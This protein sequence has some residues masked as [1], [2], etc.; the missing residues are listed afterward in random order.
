MI[1]YII[2]LLFL[3]YTIM[4]IVRLVGS[5]F[6]KVARSKF[7]LFLAFY[8][9]PYLN[10]FRRVIPPIGG[11]LDLSPLLGYMVLQFLEK[12]IMRFVG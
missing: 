7:I 2:R 9:D 11:A 12:M 6:P 5:W 3:T 10:I 1:A 4:L 8:T